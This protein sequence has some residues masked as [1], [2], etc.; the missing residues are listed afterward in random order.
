LNTQEDNVRAHRLYEWFGFERVE[1]SGFV[2]G[3][4]IAIADSGA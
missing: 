4:R 2:L 1:P 3:R